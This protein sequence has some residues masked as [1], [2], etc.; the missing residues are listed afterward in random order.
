M[1]TLTSTIET[2]FTPA[3]GDF[4]VQVTGG[5][6]TLLR[7]NTTGAA[8][9]VAQPAFAGAYICNNPIAGA[10]FKFSA[11]TGAAVVQADQ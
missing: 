10:V 2:E 1:A 4:N 9:S 11:P 3:V 6:A 7:K 8:F 5:T